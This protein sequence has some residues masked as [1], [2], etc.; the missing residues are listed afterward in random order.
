MSGADDGV[1]LLR[2]L[3]LGDFAGASPHPDG[4]L[5]IDKDHFDDVLGRIHPT[6]RLAVANRVGARGAE[7]DLSLGFKAFRDLQPAGLVAQVPGLQALQETR[8]LAAQLGSGELDAAG[9]RARAAERLPEPLVEALAARLEPHAAPPRPAAPGAPPATEGTGAVDAILDLVEQPA[10]TDDVRAATRQLVGAVAGRGRRGR[11]G[12]A[13]AIAADLEGSLGAQLDEIL[14]QP[15]FRALEASWRGLKLLVDRTDFR[16]PIEVWVRSAGV[17]DAPAALEEEASREDYDVVL[18]D[19]ELD[20][21]AR[22]RERAAALAAAGLAAQTPVVTALAPAFLG[23]GSWSDLRKARGP[24]ATFEEST[25]D[26]WRSFREREEAR[27]LVL[28][29]NRPVLRAP[30][31]PEGERARGVPYAEGGER[32]GCLGSGVWAVGASLTRAFARTGACVQVSG[33]RHGLVPDLGLVPSDGTPAPVEGVFSNERREDLERIGLAVVQQYQRDIA[34]LGP[35]HTFHRPERY[36]Q[37]ERTAD[38]AQQV[39]LA[40]QLYASRFAKFLGRVLPELIGLESAERVAHELRSH[41]VKF[42]S[43]ASKPL[44]PQRVGVSAAPNE[45]DPTLTD[46]KLRVAPELKI[47]GRDVNVMLAFSARL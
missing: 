13:D 7:L 4:V 27:W 42:L 31:G 14:H 25:Y 28:V 5:R 39:T 6:L 16:E 40:Y 23:L 2:V 1:S 3:V 38:A 43:T 21:S 8:E 12:P 10:R 34:V 47:A 29:V 35:L 9:F 44:D 33:T 30:Y 17:D 18:A 46:L 20:A 22:D 26:A 41:V 11:P 36:P 45:D 32:A 24:H 15:A 19:Y 37:P